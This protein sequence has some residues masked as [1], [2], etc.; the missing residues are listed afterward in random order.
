MRS[1]RQ[2]AAALPATAQTVAHQILRRA[3]QRP[4][5]GASSRPGAVR[6]VIARRRILA[7]VPIAAVSSGRR[8]RAGARN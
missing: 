5:M 4:S 8:I 2:A 1:A 7:R 6:R 3:Q